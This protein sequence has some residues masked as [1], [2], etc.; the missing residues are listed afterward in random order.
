MTIDGLSSTLPELVVVVVMV[1]VVVV[2]VVV[3][4]LSIMQIS[5]MPLCASSTIRENFVQ[6]TGFSE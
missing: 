2:V 4:G 5:T 3:W 6:W 1:A